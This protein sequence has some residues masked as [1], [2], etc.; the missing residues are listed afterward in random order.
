M[1][2]L[3][4]RYYRLVWTI[5]IR[6]LRDKTEADDLVQD[7]FLYV[8][9]KSRL[10]DAAKGC[11]RSWLVHLAYQRAFDRRDYLKA[12]F[13]QTHQELQDN[14]THKGSATSDLSEWI[15]L[16][17]ELEHILKRLSE[18]ERTI[19]RL[20]FFD[21]YS[22]Q[23]ISEQIGQSYGN[24]RHLYY[25]GLDQLRQFVFSREDSRSRAET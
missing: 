3:F 23:E 4:N 6:I 24:V 11:A 13:S 15:C 17:D 2:H 10:F 20:H 25:R 5:G 1:E 19:I 16:K 22:F 14:K 8:F 12:R 21:G 9:Q 18:Q 7:V